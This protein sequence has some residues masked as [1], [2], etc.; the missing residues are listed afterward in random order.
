MARIKYTGFATD[1]KTGTRTRVEGETKSPTVSRGNAENVA[2]NHAQ[3]N[4]YNNVHIDDTTY[5][6]H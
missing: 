6:E 4:G 3:L 2:R 5:T 1:S